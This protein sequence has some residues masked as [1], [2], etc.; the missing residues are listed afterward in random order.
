[1]EVRDSSRW[2]YQTNSKWIHK[3][4]RISRMAMGTNLARLEV[5]LLDSVATVA[6]MASWQV[7]ASICRQATRQTQAILLVQLSTLPQTILAGTAMVVVINTTS[8]LPCLSNNI[9]FILRPQQMGMVAQVVLRIT[10]L[11]NNSNNYL[12][13]NSHSSSSRTSIK[14]QRTEEVLHRCSLSQLKVVI[15]EGSRQVEKASGIR[16]WSQM[17]CIC[18]TIVPSR[19]TQVECNP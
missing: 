14:A 10:P 5:L 17:E 19:T 3:E 16:E 13:N 2:V 15:F 11:D 9:P 7:M 12:N 4:P 18:W 6:L 8:L 1:M